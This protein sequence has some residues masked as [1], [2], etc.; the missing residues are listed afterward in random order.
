MTIPIDNKAST[1]NRM[2]AFLLFLKKRPKI[3]GLKDEAKVPTEEEIPPPMALERAGNS[4]TIYMYIMMKY[5]ALLD[6]KTATITSSKTASGQN[7]PAS[8][9][10]DEE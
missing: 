2:F 9:F 5:K 3:M 8:R 1:A 4:S 6:L 10:T 7:S